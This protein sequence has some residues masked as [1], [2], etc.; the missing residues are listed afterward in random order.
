MVW[1]SV[2]LSII[3]LAAGAAAAPSDDVTRFY[4]STLGRDTWSGRVSWPKADGSDGPF[5]TIT[6]ARDAVR[7]LK[8]NGG[9]KKPVEV[10]IRGTGY[11]YLKE[12]IVF[13]AEDSGT[14]SC[15]ITYRGESKVGQAI[16]ILSGGH[17]ITGW[18]SDE[19]GVWEASVPDAKGGKWNPKILRVGLNWAIRARYP[20]FDPKNP[21]TGGWLFAGWHGET[22]ERGNLG[23]GIAN[24]HT[25]GDYAEWRVRVP[26]AGT[27]RVWVRYGSQMKAYNV[28]D[29]GGHYVLDVDGRGAVPL[30]RLP[31]TGGW[32]K[33]A[34][35]NSAEVTLPEGE[36]T[37]RVTNKQGG[38]IN[39][40]A[41]VLTD[42]PAWDPEKAI[43]DFTW[44]GAFRLDKPARGRHLLLIQAEA[45]DKAEGK[46]I[47]VPDPTPPGGVEFL[48]FKDGDIP[49]WKD[50]SGAEV[51]MF[52]AWGWVSGI[53]P[54]GS[55]DHAQKKIVFA[56]KA[57]QDVRMGNRY[58][59]ENVREA[60]DAPN[61]WF[62]DNKEGKLTYLP[63]DPKFVGDDVVAPKLD[64]II[65]LDGGKGYVEHLR[66]EDL[67]FMDTDYTLT[68]DYY[69][70]DDAAIRMSRARDCVINRCFFHH[71]GGYAL[72]L[73]QDSHRIE[74]TGN[75][76]QDLGQ[77]GVIMRGDN[78]NQPHHNLIAGNIMR[79][80]GL[81]YKHVAGVYMIS[82]SDNRIAHNTMSDLT[83]YATAA[84]TLHEG[85][86]SHRNIIEYN[87]IRRTNLETNDT[88]AI[89]FLGR[90]HKDTGNIVRY[91]I[92]LDSIGIGTTS[93]GR[94][95]TPFFNWGIYLDDYS[96]GTTVYGNIVGR[97]ANGALCVH[98]GKDNVFENNVF[99]DFVK[100]QIRLQPRDEFMKN[101]RFTRNIMTWGNPKCDMVYSWSNGSNWF[102]EWDRNLYWLRG[103]DLEKLDEKNTPLGTFAQ[104]KAAGN[105]AH[106]LIADPMFTDPE[107]DDYTLKPDSPAFKLGFER[108]PVE[109]IGADYWRREHRR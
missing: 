11:Y 55:I 67:V 62:L 32:G 48:R 19:Q 17:Q 23:T 81:I 9:L 80:L 102:S 28:D 71:L 98:G 103:S 40:D 104:W 66:F 5:A 25:A 18:H 35:S 21:T 76:L 56:T 72:H 88:G 101:N 22:W 37:L 60:L 30:Q 90:D 77:G 97:A 15:P 63:A 75:Q 61:E 24:F 45:C 43:G 65:V 59:I 78:T 46:E 82:A 49:R 57:A 41:M 105:D 53:E 51:H 2:L 58:Y 29:M 20:N 34:W 96:S 93:K 89:E 73:D 7:E 16:T 85:M 12:P 92:V 27:Y 14:A 87:D 68:K 13:T 94:I 54:I 1:S 86:A 108:I 26:A 10:V 70:P 79:R 36:H 100:E 109:K 38:G 8:R 3:L 95:L 84:K 69:T 50:I 39:L 47:S 33:F 42:D 91:N 107:H 74:F 4:V 6:R 83:R 31:D 99:V 52:P 44:W 64:R 106:S